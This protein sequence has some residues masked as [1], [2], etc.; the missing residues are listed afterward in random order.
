MNAPTW[1]IATYLIGI[2]TARHETRVGM[3]YRG[4]GLHQAGAYTWSL[5]HLN[6][7]HRAYVLHGLFDEVIEHATQLAEAV[8][9]SFVGLHGWMSDPDFLTKLDF[10]SATYPET[11]IRAVSETNHHAGIAAAIASLRN[12]A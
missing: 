6:S 5:T 2:S 11:V 1:T 9:W 12:A 8:D 4:L 7:G 10:V 3:T